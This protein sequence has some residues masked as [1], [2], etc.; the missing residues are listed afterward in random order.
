MT[1]TKTYWAAYAGSAIGSD[2]SLHQTERAALEAVAAVLDLPLK[3]AP[4]DDE[5]RARLDDHCSG[6]ADDWAVQE[7]ETP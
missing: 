5:L 3:D 7:V 2:I 6:S 1:T 4:D